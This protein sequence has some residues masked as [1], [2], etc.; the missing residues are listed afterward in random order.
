MFESKRV[1]PF[2]FLLLLLTLVTKW[3]VFLWLSILVTAILI[4]RP[5]LLKIPVSLLEALGQRLGTAASG[6]LL[7][8]VFY[9]IVVPY[10]VL[11]RLREKGLTGYFF[12]PN[13]K[14]QWCAEKRQWEPVSF[15]KTW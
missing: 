14:S 3:S 15:E 1:Y 9:F 7:T 6:V 2:L 13:R 8:I 4:I 5:G 11:Y 12:D 10:G